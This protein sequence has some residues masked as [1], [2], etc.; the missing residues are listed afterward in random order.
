MTGERAAPDS[1]ITFRPRYGWRYRFALGFLPIMLALCLFV[2][3][4]KGAKDPKIYLV[5]ACVFAGG[6][7][8]AATTIR[9]IR[10]G[11]RI[12]VE[13]YLFPPRVIDY[14]DIVDIGIIHIKLKKG[15]LSFPQ[16][17]NVDELHEIFDDV[18]RRGAMS[19]GQIEGTLAGKEAIG[20]VASFVAMVIA[21]VVTLILYFVRPRW[22]HLD[23]RLV[24]LIVFALLMPPTYWL[25]KR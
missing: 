20:A 25:L 11:S 19:P 2:L 14:S 15:Q 4:T 6:I 5:L 24:T 18:M 1:E 10:F 16:I 8:L 3:F 21:I 9:R 22:L 13:R 17:Q 23:F 7:V 12:I